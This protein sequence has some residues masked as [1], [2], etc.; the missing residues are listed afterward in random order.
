MTTQRSGLR[1]WIEIDTKAIDHN[2]D[3]MRSII[4]PQTKLMAVIKSNAYGHSLLDF[5]KYISE[6]GADWLGV[7]SIVEG[8]ALRE[9]GIATPILVLGFTLPEMMEKAASHDISLTI[10]TPDA[11]A[12]IE[13]LTLKKPLKV[14]LKIDTGMHRHGFTPDQRDELIATIKKLEGKII[15]EGLFTH[16]AAAKNPAFPQDTRKQNEEFKVWIDILSKAGINPAVKHASA[17]GGALLYPEAH[18]DM[19][20]IG[21]SMYGLWPSNEAEAY[22]QNKLSLRPVLRWKTVVGEVNAVKAGERVGYDFTETL[23]RDSVLADCPVGY[24]HGFPRALSGVGHVLING[25]RAKIVGRVSMDI[26]T[27]DVTDIPGVV[28]GDEVV[29]IGTSGGLS[30]SPKDIAGLVEGS[31]SYEV[32]TRLNPLIK[33]IFI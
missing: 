31:S 2:Y 17:S 11:F 3:T 32:I 29:V 8:I 5:G 4:G 20:R 33:R 30:I 19:V 10:S 25:K 24:W 23:H 28:V 18:F 12:H 1:T 22:V 13:T 26:I 9:A 14:H 15:V 6:K 27:V 7:D 21:I 16:F